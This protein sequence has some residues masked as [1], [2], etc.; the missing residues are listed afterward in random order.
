MRV[1]KGSVD[2]S[3]PQLSATKACED[4]AKKIAK[5]IKQNVL[6]LN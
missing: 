4:L 2:D 3:M 6:R 5:E 1:F